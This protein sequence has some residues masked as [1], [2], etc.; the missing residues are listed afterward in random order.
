MYASA[1]SRVVDLRAALIT[2]F[3]GREFAYFA[4]LTFTNPKIKEQAAFDAL[5][6]LQRLLDSTFY[7]KTRI[8]KHGKQVRFVG[9]L[10]RNYHQGLHWH[11]LI[12]PLPPVAKIPEYLF[13]FYV[14]H[15]WAKKIAV[16]GPISECEPLRN[17]E[18]ALTYITKDIKSNLD[19]LY[20]D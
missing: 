3:Q 18:A 10:E 12:S 2:M 20:F 17:R 7:G 4:T 5:R 8:R 9:I 16:A 1:K 14:T 11:V 15:L 13:C 19:S 6:M